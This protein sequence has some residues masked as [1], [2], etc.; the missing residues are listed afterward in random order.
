[1]HITTVGVVIG[2]LVLLAWSVVCVCCC[3]GL[4]RRRRER[5]GWDEISGRNSELDREL[6]R[7]W[8]AAG[9][10]GKEP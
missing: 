5:A 1:M 7:I 8:H 9:K 3:V 6:D 2:A 4:L 10:T